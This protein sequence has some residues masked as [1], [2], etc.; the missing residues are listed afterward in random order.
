[1]YGL[2]SFNQQYLLAQLRKKPINPVSRMAY[3]PVFGCSD[4]HTSVFGVIHMPVAGPLL[5]GVIVYPP[6][7]SRTI[8]FLF[9]NKGAEPPQIV[10]APVLQNGSC[11]QRN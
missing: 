4:G 10:G 5:S 11:C 1:M 2:F 6:S 7:K 8:L 9:G 3:S